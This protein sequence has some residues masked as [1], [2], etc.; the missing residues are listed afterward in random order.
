MTFLVDGKPYLRSVC[1]CKKGQNGWYTSNGAKNATCSG[2]A[3]FDR[4]FHIILN[5]AVGG[6]WPGNPNVFTTF[7]QTMIVKNVKVWGL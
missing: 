7:P 3:P 1:S 4:P 5:V 2:C 6:V